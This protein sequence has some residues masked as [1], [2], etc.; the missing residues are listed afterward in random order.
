MTQQHVLWLGGLPALMV[1]APAI[2][3]PTVN[4]TVSPTVVTPVVPSDVVIPDVVIPDAVIPQ[5]EAI[6]PDATVSPPTM[7]P[8][9]ASSVANPG[10]TGSQNLEVQPTTAVVAGEDQAAIAAE[11][12]TAVPL[13][14]SEPDSMAQMTSVSQLLDV[15][16]T[17]WAYQAL[18]SLVE[19][20]GIIAGL[21]DGTFQGN[22]ALT[23]YEFAAGLNAA[24]DGLTSQLAA[25]D[26]FATRE[27]LATL[28]RLQAEFSSELATLR[29]RVDTLESR[30]A[31]LAANQFSTTVVLNGQ[32]T[33]G[34]AD[35][36]GGA[37][38]GL[39]ETN[40]IFSYLAQLQLSG[41]FS[42]QDA[43]RI[44]L[45][46]SNLEGRGF[47]E[48]AALNTQMALLG[49]QGDSD[50][51]LSL[52][53]LEYRIAAGDRLVFTIKPVGFSLSSVLSPNAPLSGSS[54]GAL[55]RFAQENAIFKIGSLDAGF[56]AD[57]LISDRA[58]L[59]VA[60]GARN[61][62]R[63]DQ[64]LFASDHRAFGVQLLARPFNRV[65]TGLAYVNAFSEDGFLDTFTGS[66]NADTSGGFNEPAAIHA[67]SGTLQWEVT[68][69]VVLGAWGG[70]A[71]TDSL[72][73]D[74]IAASSTYLFSLGWRDPFGRDGDLLG[75]MVGQPLRLRYGAAILRQ[76]DGSG[77]HYEA[78]YRLRVNDNLAIVPGVFVVSDP[79]HISEND[80]IVVGAIRTSFSF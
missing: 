64:G 3:N 79:G 70:I 74:A 57:W 51:Q 21:P 54:Q 11:V 52:G 9:M 37:P 39:G 65:T 62:Q 10:V 35:A 71:V 12:Q 46:A 61:A 50:D 60:Y 42:G 4:P 17:D 22:R 49:Y 26:S 41:S 20:Y 53:S 30:T 1:M 33:F 34:L 36:W 2:A 45:D 80:T 78:F 8:E 77:M 27:D 69:E 32:V 24:L 75:V 55:S 66:N 13:Q 16:P 73:S 28:Q 7:L 25:T 40:P 67:V 19:R 38:P 31:E 29:G 56:G 44:G 76:D 14:F 63:P 6:A 48:P 23:R 72:P 68:P 5:L 47:A 43:F 58:R 18:Q 59:Q 15:R